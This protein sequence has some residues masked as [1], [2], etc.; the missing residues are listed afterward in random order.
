MR[1]TNMSTQSK[2]DQYRQVYEHA[3]KM[4]L[5]AILPD[6][7]VQIAITEDKLKTYPETCEM[8]KLKVRDCK[9]LLKEAYYEQVGLKVAYKLAQYTF[10]QNTS[11]KNQERASAAQRKYVQQ[12]KYITANTRILEQLREELIQF[13]E[14][15]QAA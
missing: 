6:L 10:E 15:A 13:R 4:K 9:N 12:K 3:E 1:E 11:L 2:L 14:Q 8:M 5:T 7:S